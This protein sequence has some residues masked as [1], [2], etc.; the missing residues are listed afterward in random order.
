MRSA[1]LA[2]VLITAAALVLAPSA[3]AA[4]RGPLT[5]TPTAGQSWTSANATGNNQAFDPQTGT[6]CDHASPASEC[7]STLLNVNVPASFWDDQGGGVEVSATNFTQA[8]ADFDMYVYRSNAAG[9]PLQLV[10]ASAGPAGREERLAIQQPSGFFLVEVV[11]FAVTNAHYT[12]NAAFF[13][14]NKLPADIDNPPGLGDSIASDPVRRFRSHSEPHIA[15]SPTNPDLLVA[16][17]K[18][19]N[20]DPDSL[21]E[22]E[23]KIGTYVSFDG[24]KLWHDLGQ[25]DICPPSAAPP[26][27][28]PTNHCYPDEDPNVGG[29]GPEDANDPRGNTDFGEEYI[30]SDVW[31]QFDDEGNAYAMVLDSPPFPSGNG[32]GMTLHRWET[33]SPE[34]LAPGGVA[35]SDRIPI[36]SYPAAAS[37]ANFALLDDKNTLGINN[38]GPDGDGQT[39]TMV[40]CWT[41][42]NLAQG[43][44]PQTI[45]CKRSTD[46]GRTWPGPPQGLSGTE[47][48]VIGADVIPDTR[49]PN[50]FY[51][52]WLD[53]APGAAGQPEEIHV[54]RSADGG[55]TWSAPRVA[56]QLTG[57][58][59]IFPQ[60]TF[61]N[62]SLPIGGV[63]PNGELYIAYADYRAAPQP[64]D[65]DNAQA[66]IMVVKSTDG[67]QTFAAPV[68]V[69]TDATDADQFQPYL[70]VTSKGQLD[71]SFF[72]RRLDV[73]QAAGPTGRAH[74]GNFFIDTWL[75]RSNDGGATFADVRVSHDSWDP[76]INPPIS[77]SG[78]FIGDYQG[79]VADDCR[80]IP[81]VNDTHL[82][83]AASRDPD[84]DVGMPRSSFQEVFATIVPNTAPFA[85]NDACPPPAAAPVPAPAPPRPPVSAARTPLLSL[86][87]GRRRVSRNGVF[88]VTMRCRS[89]RPCRVTLRLVAQRPR[90]VRTLVAT[91]TFTLAA[92]ARRSIR[93]RLNSRGRRL[94]ARAGRLTVTARARVTS[95]ARRQNVRRLMVL[96]GHRRRAVVLRVKPLGP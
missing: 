44:V 52:A 26:S 91:R 75:A 11:S 67:G 61:R 79:L 35:W 18:M 88:R 13:F 85:G 83:N 29:T 24:G 42:N 9:D 25:L 71:V 37:D 46:G 54:A 50:L 48:S 58:P 1:G 2:A 84:L 90:G 49:D 55:Q 5:V 8:D 81:F 33:P 23:F 92:H 63:G 43:A 7:D 32:W 87:S 10:A 16:A 76:S 59:N 56:A 30:T 17:S 96:V 95:S 69:N 72:D 86:L 3:G 39:G 28:W 53:V 6:P 38:A 22:Y 57:I 40:A 12:G 47:G 34:D 66:D 74:P 68:K 21:A 15:Q 31:L 94:I 78:E 82:A 64:G 93:M 70:A 4:D 14:R 41:L 89:A 60:Q 27:S 19:Y 51:V 77:G 36:N 73:P 80:A 20:R 65:A 62:L 45:V